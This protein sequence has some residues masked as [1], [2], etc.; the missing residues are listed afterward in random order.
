MAGVLTIFG[1]VVA[2]TLQTRNSLEL[3]NRKFESNKQLETQ[4]QERELI[5]KMASVGDVD[6]SRK[7]IRY[8]AE[9]GLITDKALVEKILA[10][11]D[12]PVLPAPNGATFPVPDS[13]SRRL[14][15]RALEMIASFEVNSREN[16]QKT[17]THP[18]WVGGNNGVTI[19]IGYD[20]GSV[21]PNQFNQD[22]GRLLPASD[23]DRLTVA[24]SIKGPAGRDLAT[25]LQD[26]SINW[27]DAVAVFGKQIERW[28]A[29]VDARLPNARELPPDSYGAILSIAYNRGLSFDAQGPRYAEMRA[30]KDLIEKR[31][32]DKIS[33]QIRAMKNLWPDVPG[34]QQRREREAILFEQGLSSSAG[35]DPSL[36]SENAV[37]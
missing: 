32:F 18:K 6:Q 10:R 24:A 26:I 25:S 22:W 28:S 9:T 29:S 21:S 2:T 20:L 5:L 13:L 16:Y 12:A 34:L 23:L 27:D 30:I 36:Q 17:Y 33:D 1:S 37:K 35:K 19:G 7:N 15:P 31:Q 8:L 4:K 3:E 14:S 11:T